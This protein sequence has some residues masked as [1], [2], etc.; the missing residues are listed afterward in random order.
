[1]LGA[2]FDEAVALTK[3]LELLHIRRATA[4]VVPAVEAQRWD[5]AKVVRVLMA[6]EAAGRAASNLRTPMSN[7][8]GC[9]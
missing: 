2:A 1:V 4:E 6:E 8:H 9:P 5:P 3:T 7:R